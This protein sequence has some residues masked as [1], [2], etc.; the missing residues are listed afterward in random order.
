MLKY[1]QN[2]INPS[3][4]IFAFRDL[5]SLHSRLKPHRLIEVIADGKGMQKYMKDN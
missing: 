3:S 1:I 5:H 2:M 4:L